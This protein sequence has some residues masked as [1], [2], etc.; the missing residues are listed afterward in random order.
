MNP[1]EELNK[2]R[3][4]ARELRQRT[5][6]AERRADTHAQGKQEL[7]DKNERLKKKIKELEETVE[8]LDEENKTLKTQLSGITLHKNKLVGMIFKT[9]VKK[10]PILSNDTN[11]RKLG[12]QLGHS[13]HGRKKPIRIDEEKTVYLSNCPHCQS[14]LTRSNTSYERII[15]DVLVP[16]MTK[17]TK[18]IIERQ[19]CNQC[20]K[21]LSGTPSNVLPGFRLGTNALMLILFQKYSLR[22]PL[23]KIR[24]SL[25]IQYGLAI[26][27]GA[28]A[29]ILQKL[30]SK[31]TPEYHKIIAE[32]KESPLKYADETGWR[33]KGQN[34]W[35]WVFLS[36]QA[37]AYTIEETRGKGIPD[38]FLGKH[39]SGVLVRDDYSAYK[40]LNMEQQSCWAHLLRN[41]R[42]AL[43]Q[44]TASEEMKQLHTELACLYGKLAAIVN[45]PFDKR[46][47]AKNYEYFFKKIITITKRRYQ[48]DDVKKIQTRITNQGANLI[49]ALKHSNVPL[50]NNAAERQMRPIAVIRKISGGSRS[51][52][53]AKTT[54]VNMS[55]IQTIALNKQPLFEKLKELLMPEN[56][57]WS[58]E[59]TE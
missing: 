5:A 45:A 34:G 52:A 58:L 6:T 14:T 25:K 17:I 2:L 46:Q 43:K 59:R 51:N 4:E 20:K 22:L 39:P 3:A 31:L 19:W 13:G 11:R 55:I 38:I 28:L 48:A 27:A 36:P 10:E 23:E 7:E 57:K 1:Q 54:A 37:V 32:M 26:R 40:H 16:A 9:S 21:E 35:C 15:E 33:T 12:G 49:T 42:E 8:K 56:L 50:T 41:S 30:G 24:E 18:Y 44:E 53:G 47:R 29:H